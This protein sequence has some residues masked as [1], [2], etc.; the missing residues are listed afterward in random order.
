[1]KTLSVKTRGK[2]EILNLTSLLRDAV[3][4]SDIRNG[5]LGVYCQHTT[6]ALCVSEFQTALIDD[7]MDFLERVVDGG[8]FYKHNCPEYSDC[9]RQN[10]AAHLRSLLLNHSVLLPIS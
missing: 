4:A 8:L 5:F 3:V 2:R 1:M 10:A 9:D 6:A 7:V